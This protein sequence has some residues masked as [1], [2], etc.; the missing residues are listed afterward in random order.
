MVSGDRL[1]LPFTFIPDGHPDAALPPPPGWIRLRATF[2]PFGPARVPAPRSR[3][4]TDAAGAKAD[5]GDGQ[6]SS[7]YGDVTGR[8]PFDRFSGATPALDLIKRWVSGPFVEP[9]VG[10]DAAAI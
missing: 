3:N 7:L 4:D 8:Q 10:Q 5:A 2:T 1:M 9:T 6:A